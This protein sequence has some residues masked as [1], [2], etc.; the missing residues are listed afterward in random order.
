[1]AAFGFGSDESSLMSLSLTS[2]NR[3]VV[4]AGNEEFYPDMSPDVSVVRVSLISDSVGK[5][6]A[7]LHAYECLRKAGVQPL[8][9]DVI[10]PAILL[11][12]TTRDTA[13]AALVAAGFLIKEP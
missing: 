11:A 7:I 4:L 9:C 8:G 2:P 5:G 3:R 12:P 6:Q 1:V 13:L 10:E